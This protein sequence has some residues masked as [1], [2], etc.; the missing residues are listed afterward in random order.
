MIL[1]IQSILNCFL[2]WWYD[3][4]NSEQNSEIEDRETTEDN[5]ISI[6]NE[7][8]VL[9]NA[10]IRK[11]IVAHLENFKSF[12]KQQCRS[13]NFFHSHQKKEL[14]MYHDE[15]DIFILE[16][17]L[18]WQHYVFDEICEQQSRLIKE[19]KIEKINKE[20]KNKLNKH[21][22]KLQF[23]TV[24]LDVNVLLWFSY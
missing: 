14:L 10:T 2:V 21:I 17:L 5:E 18:A 1:K 24:T 6:L 7:S 9:S 11:K 15:H 19:F 13:L 16:K 20:V 3:D 4:I 22:K 8:E 12:I 23:D